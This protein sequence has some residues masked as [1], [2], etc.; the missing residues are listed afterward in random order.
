[1][2]IV[3]CHNRAG[4]NT[5]HE[6]ELP[7]LLSNSFMVSKQSLTVLSETQMVKPTTQITYQLHPNFH[8]NV[9][10]NANQNPNPKCYIIKCQ[11]YRQQSH[12]T[13]QCPLFKYIPRNYLAKCQFCQTWPLSQKGSLWS[14]RSPTYMVSWVETISPLK[15]VRNSRSNTSYLSFNRCI[16]LILYWCM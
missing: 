7:A 13:K 11:F 8:Q 5:A 2:L 15:W 9:F 16:S 3:S 6:H 1:M 4:S 10:Y 12:S 14:Q